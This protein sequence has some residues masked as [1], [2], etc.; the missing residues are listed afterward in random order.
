MRTRSIRRL[1]GTHFDKLPLYMA[2]LDRDLKLLWGRAAGHCSAPDCKKD[3]TPLLARS[4]NVVLGE[5][6]HVIGRKPGAAR[7]DG[8]VDDSYGNLILLCADHHTLVDKAE[9]DHPVALLRKW[10][11][12]WEAKVKSTISKQASINGASC[13]EMRLWAYFDFRVILKLCDS[14]HADERGRTSPLARLKCAGV[15]DVDGFPR[16]GHEAINE[17]RTVFES[18]PHDQAHALQR[19]YSSKVEELI[20]NGPVLPLDRVWGVR[21]LRHLLFPGA[22]AFINRGFTFKT[23]RKVG[24]REWRLVRC[25]SQRVELNFEI[26]TWNAYSNSSLTLHF[27]GRSRVAALLLIRSIEPSTEK[28]GT[29]LV[30]KA[31][32]VSIGTGFWL[33]HDRTPVIAL[34]RQGLIVEVDPSEGNEEDG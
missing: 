7:S 29:G 22:L 10:K 8:T 27:R 34:K 32:P 13:L 21:K 17:P 15:V 24:E 11:H 5:M 14:I 19:Y 1:I 2:I 18:W 16:R 30:I 4:G 9:K 31:T 25:R 26:D 20:A 28:A 23:T 3:L 12:D 6:A 33:D